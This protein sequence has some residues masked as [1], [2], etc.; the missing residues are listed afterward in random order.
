MIREPL[1]PPGLGKLQGRE[2]K[3]F[4]GSGGCVCGA[5]LPAA[6]QVRD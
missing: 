5:V 6:W 2:E 1:V 4:S 3:A